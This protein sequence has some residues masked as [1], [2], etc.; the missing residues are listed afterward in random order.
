[1][2]LYSI[3]WWLPYTYIMLCINAFQNK[4]FIDRHIYYNDNK[5]KSVILYNWYFK[6]YNTYNNNLST[7]LSLLLLYHYIIIITLR[8]IIIQW[9]TISVTFRGL[10]LFARDTRALDVNCSCTLAFFRHRPD[11]RNGRGRFLRCPFP[12]TWTV[13]WTCLETL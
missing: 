10:R 1:V 11:I 4:S 12:R 7:I 2:Y 13:C 3:I 9:P 6:H 8:R 5:R